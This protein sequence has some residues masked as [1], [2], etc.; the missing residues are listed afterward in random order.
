MRGAPFDGVIAVLPIVA[1]RLEHAVGIAAPAH[2]HRHEDITVR[3]EI[4]RDLQSAGAGLGV[5]GARENDGEA[6]R[7]IRAIDVR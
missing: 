3:D 2:V 6:P 4:P 7:R 1:V 5:R